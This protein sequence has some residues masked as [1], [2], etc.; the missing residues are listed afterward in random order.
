MTDI[1]GRSEP[2]GGRQR[3]VYSLTAG[4]EALEEWLRSPEASYEVRDEGLLKLFL[5]ERRGPT[6]ETWFPP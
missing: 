5:A 2:R 6:G 1:S 4:R 3:S